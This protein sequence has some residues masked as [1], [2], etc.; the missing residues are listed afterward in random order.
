M[1]VGGALL[2]ALA[3]GAL[4]GQPRITLLSLPSGA[5]LCAVGSQARATTAI[6]A[7]PSASPAAPWVAR[8]EPRHQSGCPAVPRARWIR[9]RP[10][11]ILRRKLVGAI[12]LQRRFRVWAEDAQTSDA[13]DC[14]STKGYGEGE[15]TRLWWVTKGYRD[16]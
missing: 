7:A 2:V 10:R 9:R 13:S 4:L 3:R 12:H 8:P 11:W 16:I 6:P 14:A 5:L 15:V 1:V